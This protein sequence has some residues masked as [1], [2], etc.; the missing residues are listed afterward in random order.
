MKRQEI[1]RRVNMIMDDGPSNEDARKAAGELLTE[2][3]HNVQ[4]LADNFKPRI[5]VGLAPRAH[6]PSTDQG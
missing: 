2:F 3:L 6:E 4:V 1:E 5:E